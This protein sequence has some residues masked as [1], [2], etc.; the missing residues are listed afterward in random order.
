MFLKY[1]NGIETKQKLN[2]SINIFHTL[3]LI[4]YYKFEFTQIRL[5]S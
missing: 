5:F 3:E 1:H 2:D 4:E